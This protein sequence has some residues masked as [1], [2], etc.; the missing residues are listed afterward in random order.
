MKYITHFNQQTL[1]VVPDDNGGIVYIMLGDTPYTKKEFVYN[2]WEEIW[3]NV[4]NNLPKILKNE[5]V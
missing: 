3:N 4:A 1:Y 5:I 2:G